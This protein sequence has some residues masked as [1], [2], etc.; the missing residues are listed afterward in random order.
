MNIL[1]MI[2]VVQSYINHR[3]GKQVEIN[4]NGINLPLLLS[5]YNH[6]SEWF[7]RNKGTVTLI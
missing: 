3:T 4:P 6:A 1:E 5:A 2:A 7:M